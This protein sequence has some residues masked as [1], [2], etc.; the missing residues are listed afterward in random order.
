M[1]IEV[2]SNPDQIFEKDFEVHQLTFKQRLLRSA[3]MGSMFVGGA[4]LCAPIPVVH[5][6]L[7]PLC[8]LLSVI[9]GVWKLRQKFEVKAPD[10]KCPKCGAPQGLS[11]G[12]V[13]WPFHGYC[14]ECR[15][16]FIVRP[17]V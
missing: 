10:L 12:L 1:K 7:V 15:T 3:K 17:K 9:T 4:L 8:L 5:L 2:F 6:V 11:T 13:E 16:Q 14:A